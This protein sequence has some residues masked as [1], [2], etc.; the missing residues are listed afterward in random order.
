MMIIHSEK[1]L[2]RAMEKKGFVVTTSGECKKRNSESVKIKKPS[3]AV[4]DLR[5]N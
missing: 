2:A 4:V 1:D 3:F 5:L